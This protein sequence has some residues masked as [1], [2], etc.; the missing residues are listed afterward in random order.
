[1]G[2]QTQYGI[3]A[4]AQTQLNRNSNPRVDPK[5]RTGISCSNRIAI[6][7]ARQRTPDALPPA[8]H[9]L[10]SSAGLR[11]APLRSRVMRKR[12]RAMLR[13][14]PV[15]PQCANVRTHYPPASLRVRSLSRLLVRGVRGA[16]GGGTGA[17]S[18]GWSGQSASTMSERFIS[19][20]RRRNCRHR[21][22]RAAPFERAALGV[23]D[24]AASRVRGRDGCGIGETNHLRAAAELVRGANVAVFC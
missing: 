11:A 17:D 9:W 21:A 13:S 5:S 23:E 2:R 12:S 6:P 8:A 20:S 10:T 3:L 7:R 16:A 18:M 1:M 22:A 15:A 24:A 4:R 19:P 14:K